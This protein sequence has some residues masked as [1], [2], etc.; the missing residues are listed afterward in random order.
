MDARTIARPA[1]SLPVMDPT[2]LVK[3]RILEMTIGEGELAA[4]TG[5]QFLTTPIYCLF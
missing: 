2:H 3:G 5:K 4:A 1:I